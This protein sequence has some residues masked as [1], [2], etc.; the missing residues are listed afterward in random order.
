[1]NQAD[2]R[3]TLQPI[4]DF[5]LVVEDAYVP[6][7]EYKQFSHIIVPEKFEHGPEDRPVTGVVAG[8]G[9][10]CRNPEVTVGCRV[11]L[12]KWAGARVT[13]GEQAYVLM[14]EEDILAVLT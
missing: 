5:V 10:A 12:G 9:R 6:Y 1:M 2:L 11:L 7:H 8:K 13:F 3:V 4:N 14:K